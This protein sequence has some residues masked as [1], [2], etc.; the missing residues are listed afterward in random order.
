[1]CRHCGTVTCSTMLCENLL[2]STCVVTKLELYSPVLCVWFL[3]CSC[4]VTLIQLYVAQYYMSVRYIVHGRRCDTVTCN[5]TL[6][7][8]L[9]FVPVSS[10]IYSY[11]HTIF[12]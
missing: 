10:V 3:Y 12:K 6:C 7:E 1:M 4:V 2:Y 11:M 9:L 5:P 8:C